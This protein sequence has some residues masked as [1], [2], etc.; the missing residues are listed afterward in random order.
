[1]L[2]GVLF[3]IQFFFTLIIGLYFLNLLKSQ[4]SNKGA[5]EKESKKELDKLKRL[6]EIKLTEPLSEKT[7]PAAIKDIIG[8]E[9][10]IRALRAALCGPN[11]QHVIIYG[12]PGVGKTAAARVILEEAR[13][14]SMSPFKKEAKFVEMDATTLRFDERGIADPLIG[15]VHDPIYQGAGAYGAAGVPQPKPG[16]VTR[17][18]GGML[19][20]DEIGELHPIQMNKLLKVL[21][22]RR[23]IMESAYYSSEDNNI[24]SHIHDIFQKGLPAD[25]R[26]VGA[27][28]RQADEIPPAIRSRCVEVYFRPLQAVEIAEIAKNAAIRGGFKTEDGVE[29]IVAKY[30]QN[31][32]DAVNIIQIAGGSALVEERS[33]ITK[34][35][36]E[37]VIEFGR[38][39]PRAE[40]KV[41]AGEIVGCINGL[42]VLGSSTGIVIDIE[43]TAIEAEAEKGRL[44]VTGI[45]EEE[46]LDGRGHKLKRAGTAKSSVDNVVTVFKKV[47]GLD[48]KKY[49]IHL[50]F[51][52]GMPIDGPSA[53]IAVFAAIYSAI[54]NIPVSSEI[55]MTGE[56]SIKGKVKPV[57]GVTAKVEAAKLAGVKKVLIPKENWQEI[58]NDIGIEVIPV[59]DIG[60]V[61]EYV[62][63]KKETVSDEI[64]IQSPSLNIL[65]A[66][67]QL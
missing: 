29:E 32:R 26:L 54:F 18:H 17:A 2:T 19:F 43:A 5:I 22:D 37:W 21:E 48:C 31:G 7:R 13:K 23:V 6:R 55:A 11:P 53:G 4:Q 35:D 16:A 41:S 47:L 58:Y 25:F 39:S 24:P 33:I 51:P 65:T 10:G 40:K 1:M 45:I 46:E 59:E 27:T 3:I 14:N 66:Q 36:V 62:L 64:I 50:N 9:Q 49:D 30:A 42:A 12:P 28:T 60:Q 61:V 57:G 52:G 67:A 44:T 56:I 38:Y 15:S 8:Q 34:K 20:L 63:N